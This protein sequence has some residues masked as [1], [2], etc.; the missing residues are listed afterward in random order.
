MQNS[1]SG[2]IK[3]A[4]VAPGGLASAGTQKFL[5]MIAINLPKDKY[6][7]D[8]YYTAENKD[9]FK[10]KLLEENGVKLI[11][12]HVD[13][14]KN[15]FYKSTVLKSDFFDKWK[16]EY[17]IVQ[18]ATCGISGYPIYKIKNIPVV[19]SLHY[20]SGVNNDYNISRVMQISEFSQNMWLKRGGDKSRCV[21]VSH[22]MKMENFE[23]ID[24]RKKFGI[25]EDTFVYGFHQRNND[26][27]FSDIPLKAFKKIE[28][29]KNAFIVCGGSELYKKQAKDLGIKNV[30]FIDYT[31]DTNILYSFLKSIDVYAHGRKDGELNST[32]IA[33]AL[34]FSKPIITHYSTAFN[35]QAEVIQGNGFIVNNAD[36]YAEKMKKLESDKD[37][38]EECS[39]ASKKIFYEKYDVNS[40]LEN[41]MHIY[42]G[43]LQN[44]YPYKIHR[45]ISKYTGF[46]RNTLYLVKTKLLR[47]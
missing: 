46:I 11:E 36:E 28:S 32:A 3:L 43:V 42:D 29:D 15:H 26:Q 20:I 7:V 6:S 30:Y 37:F 5:Q 41:I 31:S 45:Y 22:P 12:F 9:D 18:I 23:F 19:D 33:E 2:K 35:G 34:Y 25:S 8:F 39:K 1:S 27:I 16:K 38:Y 24:F 17:D 14:V 21:M 44:P 13:G 40:Q 47:K 4:I 10:A